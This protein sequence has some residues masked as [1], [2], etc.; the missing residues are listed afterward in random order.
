MGGDSIGIAPAGRLT[1][2]PLSDSDLTIINPQRRKSDKRAS[3]RPTSKLHPT[4]AQPELIR[5]HFK[6]C[7]RRS[8]KFHRDLSEPIFT[9]TEKVGTMEEKKKVFKKYPP[10]AIVA[11][12]EVR[13]VK[14][15]IMKD[16]T[17]EGFIKEGYKKLIY[18]W[19]DGVIL[20]E[21]AIG[22]PGEWGKLVTKIVESKFGHMA[23]LS[24]HD[25]IEIA[26]KSLQQQQQQL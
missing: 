5:Q 15:M 19:G 24:D 18:D 3:S 13:T 21:S 1:G 10:M 22:I 14:G 9:G 17:P 8:Q 7:Y 12:H 16:D 2:P 25:S 6:R 20:W 26:L 11:S 23:L 4:N